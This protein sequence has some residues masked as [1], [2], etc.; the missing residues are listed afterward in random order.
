ML[1]AIYDPDQE[2]ALDLSH[3]DG[4][5]AGTFSGRVMMPDPGT[6]AKNTTMEILEEDDT[7]VVIELN[8]EVDRLGE[9]PEPGTRTFE[10]R[11]NDDDEWKVWS[12]SADAG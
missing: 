8:Y 3:R 5:A 4:P 10:L 7:R 2:K 1:K 11:T 12:I 9:E 6:E